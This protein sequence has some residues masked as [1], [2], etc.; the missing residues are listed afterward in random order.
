MFSSMSFHKQH[1]HEASAQIQQI[2]ALLVL[3]VFQV[4]V[5]MFCGLIRHEHF[6]FVN[7]V[8]IL[9]HLLSSDLSGLKLCRCLCFSH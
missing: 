4:L 2:R 8:P 1:T 9:D 3:L 6:F 5:K 7:C